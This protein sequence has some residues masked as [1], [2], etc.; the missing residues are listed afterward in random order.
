MKNIYKTEAIVKKVL[1]EYEDS[2]SDDFVLI[3]RV[4]KEVNE[5]ATIRELFC[6]TMLNHKEYNLPAISTIMRCRRKLFKEYPELKPKKVTNE[7]E[8]KENKIINYAID[9]YNPTF[10]DFVDRMK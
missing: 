1:E 10:M 2:R 7:R 6:H 8:K 4:F 5:W 3:Y 9:G